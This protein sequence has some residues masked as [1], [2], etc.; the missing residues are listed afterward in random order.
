M[1]LGD[2]V[3]KESS[4][5]RIGRHTSRV[6]ADGVGEERQAV[7]ARRA[8]KVKVYRLKAKE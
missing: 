5:W 3:A 4:R 6:Y 2:R 8:T 1:H 7:Q